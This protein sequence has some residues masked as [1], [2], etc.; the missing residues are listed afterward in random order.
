MGGRR[1]AT[2][3]AR[4]I[5]AASV[6]AMIV[7]ACSLTG[8]ASVE[9]TSDDLPGLVIECRG[10]P[11]PTGTDCLAWAREVIADQPAEADDAARIV[12]TDREGAGR[13]FADFQ[14]AN[15]AIYAS[16]TSVCPG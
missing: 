4:A 7:G 13:C 16:V 12:L 11:V 8:I 6:I 3:A 5:A 9:V 10:E 1:S 2:R 14:D 15:G